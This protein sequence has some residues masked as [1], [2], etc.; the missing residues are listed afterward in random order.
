MNQNRRISSAK[1]V[2]I[3]KL[4]VST[5]SVKFIEYLYLYPNQTRLFM[6]CS[7]IHFRVEAQKKITFISFAMVRVEKNVH[8]RSLSDRFVCAGACLFVLLLPFL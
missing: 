8:L 5:T 2:A 3:L 7:M 1:A 4:Y 6:C